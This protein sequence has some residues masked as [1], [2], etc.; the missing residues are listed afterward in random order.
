MT[1][2][3]SAAWE[4]SPTAPVALGASSGFGYTCLP[5]A[6]VPN[7][8]VRGNQR[9]RLFAVLVLLLSACAAGETAVPVVAQPPCA[10]GLAPPTAPAHYADGV[11]ERKLSCQDALTSVHSGIYQKFLFVYQDV[12]VAGSEYVWF[13]EQSGKYVGDWQATDS[14]VACIFSGLSRGSVPPGTSAYRSAF[15][16][17]SHDE[18]STCEAALDPALAVTLTVAAAESAASGVCAGGGKAWRGSCDGSTYVVGGGGSG[19]RS[20]WF[21]NSTNQL[22]ATLTIAALSFS[23]NNWQC[24]R[25]WHGPPEAYCGTWLG[26]PGPTDVSLCK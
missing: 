24:K 2:E 13:Y 9:W 22:R 1:N 19:T 6:G 26:K 17:I 20:V 7:A 16:I 15:S 5:C 18:C 14:P 8:A 25:I 21:F 10:L 12:G 11:V 23:P 4:N 3:N